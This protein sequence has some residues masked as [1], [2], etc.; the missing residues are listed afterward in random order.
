MPHSTKIVRCKI[1][2][3]VGNY[4]RNQHREKSKDR[5]Q[6][7]ALAYSSTGL[8]CSQAQPYPFP[9]HDL[10]IQPFSPWP[11]KFPLLPKFESL[12]AESWLIPGES[13]L[14]Q[15][16]ICTLFP[17]TPLSCWVPGISTRWCQAKSSWWQGP[18]IQRWSWWMLMCH[19]TPVYQTQVFMAIAKGAGKVSSLASEASIGTSL[20]TL[21]QNLICIIICNAKFIFYSCMLN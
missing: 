6:K 21:G 18:Q 8:S 17:W 13:F 2:G 16:L 15:F 19:Q 11:G 14:A 9:F 1:Y 10:A 4:V 20:K 12:T 3:V 7:T 5:W